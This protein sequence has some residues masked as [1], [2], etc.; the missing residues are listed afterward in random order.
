MRAFFQI[1]KVPPGYLSEEPFREELYSFEQ[2][3]RF[4]KSLAI[5]HKLGKQK[6]TNHLLSRLADNENFL[7]ELRR[8]LTDSIKRKHQV[9]P[10]GEWLLD[11]FYLIE[12]HIRIAKTHLPKKYNEGL[13]QLAPGPQSLGE[14]RIYDIVLQF[15]AHS[16]GRVDAEN[17]S[18]FIK[19]YQSETHLNLG[20]LWAVPIMLR[21]ALIENIRRVSSRIG[22]DKVDRN[23]ADYWAKQMIDTAENDPGHLILAM[24]EM[25]RSKPPMESAFISELIRQLR[26]KGPDLVLVLNWIEQQLSRSGLNSTEL[27]NVENQKQA[28]DQVSMSNSIG[29][30]RLLGVLD[31]RDFVETH[32]VVEQTLREDQG[33]VYG[34]MDFATRDRYRHVV[35]R[36]SQKSEKSEQEVARIAIRLM[37]EH[38]AEAGPE[39]RKAHVGYYLIDK[40][41]LQTQKEAKMKMSLAQHFRH[42][43]RVHAFR[44]YLSFIGIMAI[45]TTGMVLV[46]PYMEWRKSWAI[47]AGI[48]L[49][50][51]I[52]ASQLALSVANFLATLLVKPRL[53]PRMDFSEGIPA[54]SRAMVVIP[55]LLANTEAIDALVEGLEV[56]YLA[57][58]DTRLHFALLTDFVDAPQQT[59]PDDES[60]LDRAQKG[61]QELNK[62]YRR[63]DN[64][65][66]YLFQRPR[67]W[68][69]AQGT[70]MGHERKRGKLSD[71]NALLKKNATDRFLSIIGNPSI[72]PQI[73]YVI[74]LDTDT[75]LPLNTA[76]KLIGSMA[77]PLNRPVYDTG[78]KRIVQGYG[79]LQPRVTISLPETSSSWY[80]RMH[81]NEPGIDPYTRAS[82]DVY[83]DLF[84]EGSFIGKGIYDIDTFQKV[85]DQRFQEN[86]ILSHDLLEG[87]YI[88]SGLLSDVQLFEQYPSTYLTDM[89]TRLRWVRGD[90]QIFAWIL[91][92]VPGSDRRWNKNPLS[93][94]SR[95]K[96]FDNIR[97]SL[98][99]VALTLLLLLGWTLFTK[100]LF[101]TI[102][103][104]GI[105]IF[106]IVLT[107]IWDIVRKPKDVVLKYHFKNALSNLWDTIVK[108]I[109]GLICL[110]YEAYANVKAI[111]LTLWR[112]VF[113]KKNL[114]EWNPSC[115][116]GYNNVPKL[117]AF[118]S[119]M[120]IQPVFALITPIYLSI[121]YPESLFI[122]G[123]IVALWAV[124]P[125]ITWY[126]SRPSEKQIAQLSAQQD[127][128]LQKLALK[129][130]SFFDHFVTLENNWLPPDNFQEQPIELVA[131]RTSPTNIG[132]ALLADLSARYFG[133]LT[134]SQL[135]ERV[136]R[137]LGTMD[138]MEKHKGHFYNWYD[139]KS[140]SPLLPKYISTVDS[141]NLA[142]HLLVLKQGLLALPKQPI[143]ERRFFIGARD[144]LQVLY[145]SLKANEKGSLRDFAAQLDA[146][147]NNEAM[148]LRE[149]KTTIDA[150]ALAF[151]KVF[152]QWYNDWD[153]EAQTWARML[154]AQL[155]QCRQEASIYAP[156]FLE[157]AAPERFAA[158]IGTGLPASLAELSER[159]RT[160]QAETIKAQSDAPP[161]EAAWLEAF[162]DALS[163]SLRTADG[164]IEKAISLA[165][166][167]DRLADM[168]WGFLYDDT[169][170]L[171][172]IG[173]NVHEH[174]QDN[175]YY[176]LLSS[177]VRLC[178]FTCIAQD[179]LPEESWFALGRLLTNV[180]GHPILL[181]WSGSMF[182]YLMPLLV[183]PTYDNTLL[184]QTNKAAVTWQIKYGKQRGLPWG[185]SE[186]CYNMLN[187]NSVYQYR[188][189]GAR[190]LGL[191][192]GLDEDAVIAPYASAL[193][194]MIA[195]V[196][197]CENLQLLSQ[198][199]L[200]G[201]FGMYES[202][203]YTPSRLQ[204]GQNSAI[205]YAFMAHHHGMSLLSLAY[206]LL[207]KPMQQ[208]FE[209]EPEFKASLLL[210]QERIPRATAF[211]AHTTDISEPTYVNSGIETRVIGTADTPI[212]EVQLLSNGRYHVMVTNAGGSYSRWK[213]LA[214]TRW[215]PDGTRDNW[216]TF[217]YI[218]DEQSNAFWSNGYQPTLKKG[219]AYEAIFSQGR[220]DIHCTHQEIETRTEIVVSPEDD[221]E[222]RSII[223]TNH[224]SL[225]RTLEI[226]SYA[227]VVLAPAASD[228]IQPAFSNLFVQTEIL[229]EQQAIVCTRRPRSANENTPW[230][231]HLMTMEEKKPLVISYETDRARFI[232][233]GNTTREP[234]AM[235]RPGQLSGSQGSVLDPIVAI[236]YRFTLAPEE[237]VT[238]DIV[239]GIADTREHCLHL[240]SK[241]QDSKVHRDR[242]FEMAW[243]HSQVLLRQINATEADAQIYGGLAGSILFPN[244]LFRADPFILAHNCRQQS[245]LWGYSISGDLPIVLLKVRKQTSMQ[246]VRQL[247][248]AHTYWHLKGLTVD[249]VIWNEEHNDYRQSF[250]NEIHTLIPTESRDHPGGIFVRAADQI[251][252]EDRILF[253]TVARLIIS[254]ENGTLAN[255]L[256][257]KP[258]TRRSIP[259]L[260]TASPQPI[261]PTGLPWP[262]DLLFFN[263]SGGFSPDGQEYV[264][265]VDGL[266][267][268]PAPWVNVIAHNSFGTVI[269]ESGS[270]YTWTEN[271]HELRLT[272]WSNDAVSDQGG[273]AFYIRDEESGRFWSPSP[274]PAPGTS[275]YIVRHGF[276]YS[277]F[278][279][280][281]DGIRSE[282]TVYVAPGENIKFTVLKIRNQSGRPRQLSATGYV[283][284][285]LGDNRIKTAMYIQ[286]EVD[287][288]SGALLAKNPYNTE[289]G[290][291]AAFFDANDSKSLTGDRSEFI[292][293]NG[294]LQ[295]PDAMYRANLSGRTGLA[296]DP[297]AAM[298][299][300]LYL[301]EGEEQEVV[302]RL[303]GGADHQETAALALKYKGREASRAAFEAVKR[304]W[305]QTLGALKIT[306]PDPAIDILANGWLTYQTLSSRLWGRSGFYQSGGAFG[307][308][309]QLQ[310][311][312]SLL[313]AAPQLAREHILLC[314]SRQFKEGDVQHWWHPPTGRGVRTRISDDYLWLPYVTSVY[315]AHTGD[316]MILKEPAH[317][318][319]GRLL[320]PDEESYFD[321]PLQSPAV[322]DLYSHCVLAIKHALQFGEHGMPLIGTGDW[323]DGLDKVGPHGKGESV[324][325]AF[326]LYDVLER[327]Q[328][329]ALLHN[330]PAFAD[331]CQ[332]EAARLKENID[333]HAWD[334]EWYKRAWFDDGTALG[335]AAND[336]CKIDS[337]AQSWAVLSGAGDPKRTGQAMESAYKHLVRK[338][339][340]IIQLLEPPFDKS[341]LEPGYIKGYVPGVRENGGQYTHAAIW[342]I[343]A[344]AKLG[345]S[346]K[347]WE[348]L[349][350]VHPVHHGATAQDIAVYKVEPYVVAADVY[351]ATPHAGRGG[352]TWYTGAAGWMYQLIVSYFL[353]LRCEEATLY[354][355]PCLPRHWETFQAAYRYKSTLYHIEVRQTDHGPEQG[356]TLDGQKIEGKAIGLTDDKGEHKVSV[357]VS[358]P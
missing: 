253:Q 266:N 229:P 302:F 252:D 137:T 268:T 111:A 238:I 209:A 213:D 49:L 284:W 208:L 153:A 30:L 70:W 139:T 129:T 96:I 107:S 304:Y 313:H 239:T 73:K 166:A 28:A 144:T 48:V 17:L 2:M 325:L 199:G 105:I 113:S 344:F 25:V 294:S 278:E 326:F 87:C 58:R 98:V 265:G 299:V 216:G 46:T 126:T 309:D 132:L 16:D 210:L 351:S 330:D 232:G 207:D 201:R 205:I 292:G 108:T 94:L 337:I 249:L 264:I 230:M 296:M 314:A 277:V 134:S 114:L 354:V 180:D 308:R 150:L 125:F 117:A 35:E 214:V 63:A 148:D 254:D 290:Q 47:L 124:A 251:S 51:L 4:G 135:L 85:L 43:A 289:Y 56:R 298:Q 263:G 44:A 305:E 346:E 177:E 231:F 78:K 331:A 164:Y 165:R 89:R 59:M 276:G 26:G 13:P 324:W 334:G 218:W 343:M 223:I 191:K 146:A 327:F 24:A 259:Y 19:A 80:R 57:N 1:N 293:R 340:G 154:K 295:N 339:A 160:L 3:E 102:V 335:T 169:S 23:L 41:V 18:R 341:A 147:C 31:W 175:S 184:D 45:V 99:P 130:W 237:K 15:I 106:P 182:E 29:S 192:R 183:M 280:L 310:D 272:P 242:V 275:L 5:K 14:A 152:E 155:D 357:V 22:I 34:D 260:K 306:T 189:F 181:S 179:K 162:R 109:F 74:T 350:M 67:L 225:S 286:T 190:G 226:T 247:V 54:D 82:S 39:G 83:Q 200:E 300:P 136:A 142:G 86:R 273:E 167:C 353:G 37:Q 244:A 186:S 240:V 110:P 116:P 256:Q 66:F 55:A 220:A 235:S 53:L 97:R 50:L 115:S 159:A 40:G 112:M 315:V 143:V 21:L 171:L 6:A 270:A 75:Q 149:M 319:E 269:S 267:K 312:L 32:S 194:L 234:E 188:A 228:L 202:I 283:E 197:A 233:R 68:N 258:A 140:L 345:D 119:A 322:I 288:E 145:D 71:L 84:G 120:W 178:V 187:A 282:M 301:A 236:R 100:P 92:W 20:E 227:E 281:E 88:R 9:S 338:E 257:R 285:V 90:W 61:I 52:C 224:S 131:H 72:L 355:Q 318:L 170:H 245:G 243:T 347:V 336:E 348:L 101:W 274:G 323:N 103:V 222:M 262:Q 127:R 332:E 358:Y 118:Y 138:K 8:L 221:I 291:R 158:M 95:W 76:W 321:L 79:I 10:A 342:L 198:M 151:Q 172:S 104:S 203:D 196:K 128:F 255:H 77:H 141:G 211:F 316:C 317:L 7:Q 320:H 33:G 248:Q 303:G 349:N 156:W 60:L 161:H 311:V 176:D 69:A 204:R 219:T 27:V 93:G 65:L 11:N 195:P 307:Y 81:G 157:Q 217:C 271:A 297:C 64:D 121:H 122:A 279:H 193:A 133:Y 352:W 123:P 163:Q 241:Y 91:P 261:D 36:I 328:A 329:V 38:N 333:K 206:L 168:E 62:K 287:P 250:Q 246:L 212:P 42:L 12:E 185:V 174:V 356:I 215:R 173:Y